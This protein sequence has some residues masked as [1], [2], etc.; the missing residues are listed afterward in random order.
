MVGVK[1]IYLAGNETPIFIIGVVSSILLAVG[2]LPPYGEMWKR[3]GRVKGISFVGHSF[4]G[5][6]FTLLVH[7][8]GDDG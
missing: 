5:P 2:L 1:P 3:H 4:S 8:P 7:M 6:S